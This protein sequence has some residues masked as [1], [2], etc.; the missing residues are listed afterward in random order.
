MSL[1]KFDLKSENGKQLQVTITKITESKEYK[2]VH[3][4]DLSGSKGPGGQLPPLLP[5]PPPLTMALLA[6]LYNQQLFLAHW[7]LNHLQLLAYNSLLW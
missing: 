6:S 2:S 4:L 5:P 3:R 1:R 7:W